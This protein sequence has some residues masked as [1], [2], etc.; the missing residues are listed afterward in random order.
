MTTVP[1][2]NRQRLFAGSLFLLVCVLLAAC[3]ANNDLET[4]T[5]VEPTI[6]ISPTET[7]TPSK[8]HTATRTSTITLTPSRT[9]RPT[10]TSTTSPSLTFSPTSAFSSTPTP[11]QS[12]SGVF[13]LE[14]S[15]EKF[16]IGLLDQLYVL[17]ESNIY[18]SGSFGM[19]YLDL[20]KNHSS[21]S[22][23]R[24][25]VLGLD[26]AGR[27]W[28][29]SDDGFSITA[30]DGSVFTTYSR[31]QGWILRAQPIDSSGLIISAP[32]IST[33]KAT[34]LV[35]NRDVRRF[36][37][38]RWRVF[39]ATE[40]GIPVSYKAGVKTVFSLGLDPN[41]EDAWLGS[42]NWQNRQT[43]SGGGIWRFHNGDWEVANFPITNACITRILTDQQS[44]V[45]AST[46]ASLWTFQ[47]GEWI[48]FYSPPN[49]IRDGGK[50]RIEN[51]W[52]D[53]QNLVLILITLLNN[54]GAP[55]EKYLYHIQDQQQIKNIT[56]SPLENPQI[57]FLPGEQAILFSNQTIYQY[58]ANSNWSV[59]SEL[60]YE[61][62][63]QDDAK[64]IWLIS[65][66]K[67]RPSLWKLGK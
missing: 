16:P 52:I 38:E 29:Y 62:I 33:R 13:Q 6:I 41:S 17:D 39:T 22:R 4:T 18:F 26:R 3:Q 63:A 60:P 21:I 67:E 59:I 40:I 43:L 35:T 28:F 11:L 56:F 47:D 20:S 64:N 66:V 55:Q 25:P 10:R 57:F 27:L 31:N 49:E 65:S 45:W 2:R 58:Q 5:T 7:R 14:Y 8:T 37:G 46:P 15:L 34:W 44:R 9:P 61:T 1:H 23:F 12:R 54:N 53:T 30:W 42:C 36:D 24:A 19:A 48:E 51:F 32:L 50:M